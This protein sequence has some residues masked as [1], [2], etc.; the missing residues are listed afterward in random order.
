MKLVMINTTFTQVIIK[1]HGITDVELHCDGKTIFAYS[2]T[3]A[4]NLENWEIVKLLKEMGYDHA[5]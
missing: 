3:L 4:R 2:Y 1:I 5:K